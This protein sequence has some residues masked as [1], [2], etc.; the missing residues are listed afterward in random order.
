MR[1]A[2]S[3]LLKSVLHDELTLMTVFNDKSGQEQIHKESVQEFI[4][5]IGK[6]HE[7]VYNEQINNVIIHYD[8][9][10]AHAWMDYEFFLDENFSHC[11]VNAMTLVEENNVWKIISIVDTR[12]RKDCD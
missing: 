7:Y 2:D 6:P 10:L 9:R 3:V 5:T 11:G 8:D 12:R 4:T 1:D